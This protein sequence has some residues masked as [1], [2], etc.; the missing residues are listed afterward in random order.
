MRKL[1]SIIS[2]VL[3]VALLISGLIIFDLPSMAT[4][5][6]GKSYKSKKGLQIDF[7]IM[8]DVEELGID[9]GFINIE[10]EKL[11]EKDPSTASAESMVTYTYGGETYYFHKETV[12]AY[13]M[14]VKRLT[15]M[16]AN[17]TAAFVNNEYDPDHFSYMYY[18]GA[19]A[20]P[21]G[22]AYFAFNTTAGSRG[23]KT[24]QAV[25][26]FVT[27]RYN[28]GNYGTI[29]NF[30]IGNEVND[31][32]TYNNTGSMEI[33]QYVQV[34]YQT[35]KTFY[36]A[37]IANNS[38]ARVY[39]P[40]EYQWAGSIKN[41]S[42]YYRGKDF[43]EKFNALSNADGNLN[44]NLAYHPYSNP[45][46]TANA[47]RDNES[48]KNAQGVETGAGDVT[49][50]YNE[51]TFITMKNLDALTNFMQQDG[52]RNSSGQVRSIILSEQGYSSKSNLGDSSEVSQAANIAYAY[53]KAEMN[54]FIDAFILYQHVTQADKV[55]TSD[56]DFGLWKSDSNN[57]PTSK[58]SAYYIYKY[59]DTNLSEQATKFALNYFGIDSWATVIDGFDISKITGYGKSVDTSDMY[60]VRAFD[61]GTQGK[62]AS[63]HDVNIDDNGNEV[64]NSLSSSG[65][66][67][68]LEKAMKD[69]RWIHEYAVA[70]ELT[71]AD[72]GNDDGSGY[73]QYHP[74]YGVATDPKAFYL[75]FQ[76]LKY[77][78]NSAQ[79]M[80]S[81]PYLG[82]EFMAIPKSHTDD[83]VLELRVRVFSGNHILDSNSLIPADQFYNF[84]KN[85]VAYSKRF[86]GTFFVD[87]SSWKY[88]NS[89]DA[90]EVWIRDTK[91]ADS[92]YDAYIS[93]QNLMMSESLH[94]ATKQNANEDVSLQKISGV[95][96]NKV[97]T[98]C[99]VDYSSE[100]DPEVY[101]QNNQDLVAGG[102][103]DPYELIEHY[104]KYGKA[105]GRKA[106]NG[107]TDPSKPEEQEQTRDG[108]VLMY[109]M[110]NPNNGEHFYTGSKDERTTLVSAG[111]NY[112]GPAWWAPVSGGVPV[113]RLY[114]P[115]AG[116]HHYTNSAKEKDDL[117]AA[118]WNYEGIAWNDYGN[119]G[120]PLYRLYN[121]NASTGSHHYTMSPEERDNLSAIGWKYEGIGWFG[122]N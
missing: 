18:V 55:N 69:G 8:S 99:G 68:V 114:N 117:I 120:S 58:K 102:I 21:S 43:L 38:S 31:N 6:S 59:I 74:N 9:E 15:E 47:L 50:D 30:V 89:V 5:G 45:I 39:V 113:Y 76:G 93:V 3:S 25:C 107:S 82:F 75:S 29:K 65:D 86:A 2:I 121:P 90:V 1:K 108:A 37:I 14:V 52:L 10:F 119:S 96:F 49:S 83:S 32:T 84:S 54:P 98:Y 72:Y 91:Y 19:G 85:N 101:A 115:Y 22:V 73:Q 95:N 7:N 34:Y 61:W 17:V 109:R 118:G 112:E 77:K 51:T 42:E 79:D 53:Y 111:W 27:K 23:Q 104:V 13:D 94:G 33:D 92:S 106:I 100:F 24:V 46:L 66:V 12:E 80:S 57:K 4:G 122:L 11:L 36:D 35:F 67:E 116:D 56:F 110:Y 28:N 81:K 70:S 16:G 78:F 105:E 41:T 44:W 87:L 63:G 20:N 62:D 40:L 71:F 60:Y 103:N 64:S 48:S 97:T 88:K 26:D